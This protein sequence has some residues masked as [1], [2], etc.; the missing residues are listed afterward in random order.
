RDELSARQQCVHRDKT[1]EPQRVATASGE[2]E[3][4]FRVVGL[5]DADG[6]IIRTIGPAVLPDARPDVALGEGAI[7]AAATA[8]A[9][10]KDV[11]GCHR[12][13]LEPGAVICL[14][15]CAAC[16]CP[17]FSPTSRAGS[18]RGRD[19]FSLRASLSVNGAS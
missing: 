3:R 5:V 10:E 7:I 13:S 14:F 19:R 18:K 1:V 2:E 4:H 15:P 17:C 6:G 8:R 12:F 9:H 16:L 11:G